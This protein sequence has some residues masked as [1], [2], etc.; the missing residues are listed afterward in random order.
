[1]IL[2]SPINF[3]NGNFYLHKTFSI[4]NK[5]ENHVI[6]KSKAHLGKKAFL[7]PNTSYL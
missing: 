7:Y 3:E 1:M 6:L 5:T 4:N 2:F